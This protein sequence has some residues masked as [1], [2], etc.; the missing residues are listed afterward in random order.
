ME[1]ILLRSTSVASAPKA[2]TESTS[3]SAIP[4]R[5]GSGA[6]GAAA[7]GGGA[8]GR[9]PYVSSSAVTY[10]PISDARNGCPAIAAASAARRSHTSASLRSPRAH[11]VRAVESQ[12][13]TSSSSSGFGFGRSTARSAIVILGTTSAGSARHSGKDHAP[14]PGSRFP[15]RTSCIARA[16]I[17]RSPH[18]GCPPPAVAARSARVAVRAPQARPGAKLP[19][20]ADARARSGGVRHVERKLARAVRRAA[21]H[22]HRTGGAHL[23]DTEGVRTLTR[24]A[25]RE[26]PDE[27]EGRR[28]RIVRYVLVLQ[29]LRNLAD[30]PRAVLFRKHHATS[31]KHCVLEVKALVTISLANQR[32]ARSMLAALPG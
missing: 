14:V 9:S 12:S 5:S 19:S 7:T 27:D 18:D 30:K 13:T 26:P 29:D 32:Q 24:H 3:V 1:V 31:L 22:T 2:S 23:L 11:S 20:L 6:G 17:Q 15:S 10:I 28:T 8:A 21:V 4:R 25:A 16:P